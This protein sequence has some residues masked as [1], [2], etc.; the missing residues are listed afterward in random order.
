VRGGGLQRSF[1]TLIDKLPRPAKPE[2]ENRQ[3]LL[4]Q[5]FLVNTEEERNRL[6]NL[7]D[8]WDNVPRYSISRQAMTATRI[9]GEFL[10]HHVAGS[11]RITPG[12]KPT[13]ASPSHSTGRAAPAEIP[14]PS[15]EQTAKG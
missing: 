13:A 2:F 12:P 10:R 7:T 3:L 8:L 15:P 4:F 1:Q 9:D 11:R 6:S 5:D 14:L